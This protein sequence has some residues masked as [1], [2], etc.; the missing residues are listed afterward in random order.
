M[1]KTG[2]DITLEEMPM[3]CAAIEAAGTVIGALCQS[4]AYLETDSEKLGVAIAAVATGTF[5]AL[6]PKQTYTTR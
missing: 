3:L 5:T 1:A 4:G 2:F 6:T